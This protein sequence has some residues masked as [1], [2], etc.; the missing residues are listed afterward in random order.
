MSFEIDL[1]ACLV[2]FLIGAI[3]YLAQKWSRQFA[4]PQLRFSLL[5]VFKNT[6]PSWRARL[7]PLS[8]WLGFL[9]LALFSLAFIDPR[10]Y[11]PKQEGFSQNPT[12]GIAIYLVLDQSGSMKNNVVTLLPSGAYESIKKT[13]LLK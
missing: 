8:K 13:E 2:L 6:H 7:A 4:K 9:S 10:F 12:K 3:L 11:L 5:N 1:L